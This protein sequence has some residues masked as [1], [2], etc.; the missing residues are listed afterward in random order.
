MELAGLALLVLAIPAS[1]ILGVV[2]FVLALNQRNRAR[3]L[4]ER[5]ARLE[6]YVGTLPAATMPLGPMTAPAPPPVLPPAP[7][8]AGPAPAPPHVPIPLPAAS[9][10]APVSASV[11]PIPARTAP[12]EPAPGFEE[13]LGSRWAVWVGGL[14]LA[15]GGV[16]LVRY[17]IEQGLLGPGARLA[18]GSLFAALLIA[19]GELMRRRERAGEA[20][21]F[22]SAHVPAVL[23]AA[24]TSTAFATCYAAYAL[25][26]LLPSSL[27]LVLLG[28]IAVLTMLAAS[29]HGPALAALGLVGALGSP[30]L[31]Q[32]DEPRP[33]PLVVYIACV[34]LAAYGV[35]RLRLW[36]WLAVAAATGAL[37]W[38][39][40]ML[41]LG[42]RDLLPAMVHVVVQV[43]LAGLFLVADP[44]RRIADAEARPDLL[45]TGVLIGFAALAA[46]VAAWPSAGDLRPGFSGLVCLMLLALALRFAPAASGAAAA[47]LLAVATLFAWPVLREAVAEPAQLLPSL[48]EGSPRPQAIRT[49]VI[50][51][52]LVLGV[53]GG[54]AFW[55][56]AWG[57]ALPLPTAAWYAGAAT[58]GPLAALV[59]AYWRVA[60]F[61]ASAS[62]ALAA[63]LLALAYAAITAHLR[64]LDPDSS[65][66][67]RLGLGAAASAALAALA[68]GLTFAL[69]RGLLTVALALSALGAAWVA[70][71]AR[72]PVLRYA[73][74]AIGVAVLGR[75]AYDPSVVG[76]DPGR[77][78]ILNW[79]LVGYGVPG[80]AFFLA[81]RIL[82]RGGR[83]RVVRLV[84][85]L[86]LAFAALLAFFEIRHALNDGDPF[87][88]D[89]QHLE[90]GL[91]A[92]T[93]LVFSLV[94]VRAEARRPDIVYRVGALVFGAV[95]LLVSAGGLL[96]FANPYLTGEIVRG[97]P[98]L[99]S[100][101]PAYLL[102]AVL[103]G[104]LALAARGSR[105]FWYV[106][107]AAGLAL[108][109]QLAYTLLAI[110]RVFQGPVVDLWRETSQGEL[111]TYSAAL[112]VIGVALLALGFLRQSRALRLLSAGYIIAAVVKVFVIDLA[113]LEGVTR[114]L[115][116]IGLGLALVGIGLAYQ[117]LLRRQL[118]PA[119]PLANS[120]PPAT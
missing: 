106:R 58:I 5:L 43:G 107:A 26:G 21:T 117:R 19:A 23:T 54:G 35:A 81:S 71:R 114:A 52:T 64:R 76:G 98:L 15:L 17:S 86:A 32:S 44:H 1:L 12:V 77:T 66:A 73:V 94:L 109:L 36:R 89:A 102:P 8:P 95:T 108:A 51:A 75:L 82:A 55:R 70:E 112:L 10:P 99:N 103:A 31:V 110:R 60:W 24:G 11:P 16:F 85:S 67:V 13:R 105:P 30:L 3:V 37:L 2:G 14:A 22:R 111:W 45:A 34:V 120:G 104:G 68:A 29:L 53:I 41:L 59:V 7:A 9:T 92:T 6:R 49:F 65:D 115:S 116:F 119:A 100:L 57:R 113:N 33:W 25:Y 63:G 91:F 50:F 90:V 28:G 48:F 87:V 88:A 62:L 74:G 47:A 118:P 83:D 96:L 78:P 39:V 4:E 97:G 84:E 61:E 72:L 69:E 27:A 80:V 38:G 93:G 56:I 101:L 79:L 20:E 18:L 46:L 42:G 40:T